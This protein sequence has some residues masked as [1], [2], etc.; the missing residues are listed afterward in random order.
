M[1]GYFLSLVSIM[2]VVFFSVC[3][4]LSDSLG[5]FWLFLEL[6]TLSLVPSFFLR[7]GGG[8]L[9]AL[10]NYLVVSSISSSLMICG[11][12]YDS[13]LFLCF[14]GLLVKF[15][16][17]PFQGWVYKVL[18]SSGWV[19]VWGFSVFLKVPFLFMCFFLGSGGSL[20]LNVACVLSFFLLGGLFWCYSFSWCHC[21]CHMMLSSSAALMAMSVSGSADVLF[22][23]FVVYGFWSS[24]VV[25]FLSHLED[26][27]LTGVGAYFLFLMLLV[28]LPISVS[29]F[30]KVWMAV[31]IYFCYFPVFVAWCVYSVSEQLFLF[32]WLIKDSV[33]CET[34]SGVLLG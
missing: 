12:L 24:A 25:L 15:G 22:Y 2:G 20:L 9:E 5:L 14:L 33:A 13:L 6:S 26:M 11:F 19:V 8:V 27:G 34:Y 4:F 23:L 28:S 30:Y 7:L 3:L 16:V 10:F 18:L 21:W 1:W 17:F 32:S 29:V 31:G